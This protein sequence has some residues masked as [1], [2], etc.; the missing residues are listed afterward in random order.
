MKPHFVEED[1]FKGVR[2]V[3]AAPG[4]PF[5]QG[6]FG[7]QSSG[8]FGGAF[9]GSKGPEFGPRGGHIK[10]ISP[11]T[12]KPVYYK[13]WQP[14]H[15]SVAA[16]LAQPTKGGG[17]PDGYDTYQSSPKHMIGRTSNGKPIHAH[18]TR[19]NTKHYLWDDHR[20]A[21]HAH[22]SLTHY[23]MNMIRDRANKGKKTE[24]L[25]H[26]MKLHAQYSR[27]HKEEALK[28]MLHGKQ[29]P[30]SKEDLS[31]REERSGLFASG[32]KTRVKNK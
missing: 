24:G 19:N 13:K 18:S 9:V 12:G 32:G 20:D 17:P 16:P 5:F 22:F 7:A 28:D 27:H 26:L 6:K 25:R 3:G 21:S 4:A 8:Q 23:L 31:K 2:T 15:G 11:T 10:E 14:K 29:Q 1:V 30:L